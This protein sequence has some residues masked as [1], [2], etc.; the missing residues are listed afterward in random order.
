MPNLAGYTGDSKTGLIPIT[1]GMVYDYLEDEYVKNPGG[2]GL[3]KKEL[4]PF[5]SAVVSDLSDGTLDGHGTDA[6]IWITYPKAKRANEILFQ[7]PIS[8]GPETVDLKKYVYNNLGMT[9]NQL[10]KKVLF[11]YLSKSNGSPA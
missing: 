2:N 3:S 4:D 10:A 5:Y 6:E 11:H 8:K 1:A 7:I 9:P